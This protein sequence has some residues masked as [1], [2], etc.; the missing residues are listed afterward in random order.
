MYET[1]LFDFDGTLTPSLTI[2]MASFQYALKQYNIDMSDEKIVASCFYRPFEDV[3]LDHGISDAEE[4]KQHVYDGLDQGFM[5][6]KTVFGAVDLIV[7][8]RSRGLK[9][10]MVTSSHRSL[11]DASL[12]RLGLAHLFDVIVTSDDVVNFKPH[13]EPVLLALRHLDMSP[14]TALFVGDSQADILSGQAAHVETALFLPDSHKLYYNFDKLRAL[15][16]T[17]VFREYSELSKWI[18]LRAPAELTR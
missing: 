18:D 7:D 10:G 5:E 6:A 9:T 11:V 13:P 1:I 2:W 16:P 12:P 17:L 15:N 3:A 8:C 14:E 4:L